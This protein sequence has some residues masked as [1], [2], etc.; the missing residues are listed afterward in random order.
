MSK[1]YNAIA[2]GEE[3]VD[4][5]ASVIVWY[6]ISQ[7]GDGVGAKAILTRR[8]DLRNSAISRHYTE[9]H[10]DD[11]TEVLPS[12]HLFEVYVSLTTQKASI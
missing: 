3:L 6:G 5:L 11:V 2:A 10:N 7:T 1:G 8:R 4:H 9:S 12:L